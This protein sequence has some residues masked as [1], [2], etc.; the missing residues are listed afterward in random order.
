MI[1]GAEI[2]GFDSEFRSTTHKYEDDGVSII[3]FSAQK[4]IFI[5]DIIKLGTSKNFYIFL[6]ELFY[7]CKII[8]VGHTIKSDYLEICKIFNLHR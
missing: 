6:E 3:Q 7:S 4:K 5:F 2:V 1:V 8:K